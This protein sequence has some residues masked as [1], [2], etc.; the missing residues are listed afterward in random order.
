M[1]ISEIEKLLGSKAKSLLTHTCK[2]VS[3]EKLRLPG[4]DW[5]ERIFGLS[6]RTVRTLCSLQNFFNTGRLAKTVYLSILPVDQGIEHS[7]GAS[8][9]VNPDYFD[10]ENI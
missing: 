3:K 1:S 7:A 5:V 9:A 10:P 8:F 2:T 6:D 4:P